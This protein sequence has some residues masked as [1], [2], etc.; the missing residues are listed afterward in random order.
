MGTLLWINGSGPTGVKTQFGGWIEQHRWREEGQANAYSPVLAV[1]EATEKPRIMRWTE[2]SQWVDI[3]LLAL[4]LLLSWN[5]TPPPSV[6]SC[7]PGTNY[8]QTLLAD[9]ERFLWNIHLAPVDASC[10][11]RL[12]VSNVSFVISFCSL[13]GHLA[14]WHHMWESLFQ[15]RTAC[16]VFYCASN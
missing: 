14:S 3:T 7:Q 10:A 1:E 12:M 11:E 6:Y 5:Y 4:Y 16:K 2:A 9:C 13:W 8:R 15:I